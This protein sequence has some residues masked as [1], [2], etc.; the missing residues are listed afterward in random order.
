LG[1]L[2][3]YDPN[4]S[5]GGGVDFERPRWSIPALQILWSK[6]TPLSLV[7]AAALISDTIR[8]CDAWISR[9]K[10]LQKEL[11]DHE[12]DFKAYLGDAYPDFLDIINNPGTCKDVFQNRN[13]HMAERLMTFAAREN[14]PIY[15]GEFGEAHTVLNA[16][17]SMAHRIAHSPGWEDKVCTVNLYCYQ[18][19][20]DEPV[21]NWPLKGME[22]DIQKYFLPLC[23]TG[24]TLFDLT[25]LPQYA[26]YGQF[27]IVAKG[28]H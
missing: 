24:F 25:S 28:Q 16:K 27:L 8:D 10:A 13:G 26:A 7:T 1:N 22:A 17:Q 6:Q 12:A 18:C 3:A 5:P 11:K 2:R 19:T 23:D 15:F 9:M 21:N 20:A 4:V 14:D